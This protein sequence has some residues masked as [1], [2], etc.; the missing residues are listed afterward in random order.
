MATAKNA[1]RRFQRSHSRSLA[2]GPKR[3]IGARPFEDRNRYWELMDVIRNHQYGSA[4]LIRF[5]EDLG[6]FAAEMERWGKWVVGYSSGP[7]GGK[8]REGHNSHRNGLDVDIFFDF[9][10]GKKRMTFEE[11]NSWDEEA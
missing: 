10:P 1:P 3:I 8:M 6:R 5:V 2:R 7:C 11:R 4:S 9:V